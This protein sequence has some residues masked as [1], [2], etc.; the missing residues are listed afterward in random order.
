LRFQIGSDSTRID[1]PVYLIN[2]WES[3]KAEM[4]EGFTYLPPQ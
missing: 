4:E 2:R 1:R 3:P